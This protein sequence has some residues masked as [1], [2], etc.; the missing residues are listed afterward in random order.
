MGGGSGDGLHL[1]AGSTDDRHVEPELLLDGNLE[2]FDGLVFS[3]VGVKDE[4]ARSQV[5]LR[6]DQP[7]ARRQLSQW[8]HRDLVVR[9]QVDP[10]KQSDPYG[11]RERAAESLYAAAATASPIRSGLLSP[12]KR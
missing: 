6:L 1:G 8:A 4:I 5:G 3:Q 11:H 2:S 9:P 12:G 10:T 7:D